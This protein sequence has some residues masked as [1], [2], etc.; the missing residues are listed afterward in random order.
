M[1]TFKYS[2]NSHFWQG[3]LLFSGMSAPT[4]DAG[5]ESALFAIVQD[6]GLS[7]E[8]IEKARPNISFSLD[9]VYREYLD[10]PES[11]RLEVLNKYAKLFVEHVRRVNGADSTVGMDLNPQD[12]FPILRPRTYFVH[13]L[14]RGQILSQGKPI[15]SPFFTIPFTENFSIG[16]VADDGERMNVLTEK[17]VESL[18][19]DPEDLYEQAL[20]NLRQSQPL[21]IPQLAGNIYVSDQRGYG[22]D[23][24]L[25]LLPE[26]LEGLPFT[27]PIAAFAANSDRLFVTPLQDLHPKHPMLFTVLESVTKLHHPISASPFIF[28]DGTWKEL[29]DIE[30][31]PFLT[32]W[33]PVWVKERVQEM[34]DQRELIRELEPEREIAE[35][36]IVD[37]NFGGKEPFNA[38]ATQAPASLNESF[39]LTDI[40][41]LPLKDGGKKFLSLRVLMLELPGVIQ[42]DNRY[43]PRLAHFTRNLTLEELHMLEEKQLAFFKAFDAF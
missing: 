8:E 39:F 28:S 40:L 17:D 7:K 43:Q 5:F 24:S 1:H 10:L 27:E 15:N 42:T 6:L 34:H 38:S 41:F 30:H 20:E 3:T 37:L 26:C 16:L 14:F 36:S 11:M 12:I 18:K 23:G 31:S 2:G 21:P 13:T 19:I 25:L 35:I 29:T 4:P 22:Y 32:H 33:R 9:N